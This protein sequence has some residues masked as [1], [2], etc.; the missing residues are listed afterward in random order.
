VY[1]DANASGSFS[2]TADPVVS[3]SAATAYAGGGFTGSNTYDINSTVG[4]WPNNLLPLV[5]NGQNLLSV[6]NIAF[7]ND[8]EAVYYS[9]DVNAST[10]PSGIT[11]SADG[12]KITIAGLLIWQ[13]SNGWYNSNSDVNRRLK[14]T[15]GAG[16]SVYTP[17][18]ETNPYAN[19]SGVIPVQITSLGGTGWNQHDGNNHFER[20]GT[21]VINGSGLAGVSHVTLT[22]KN[23]F[24]I[25]LVNP[26][27]VDG[28]DVNA[29]ATA[30]SIGA[31]MFNAD[32]NLL[33]SVVIGSRR[34]KLFFADASI[35]MS[36]VNGTA[37]AFTVSDLP[38][39]NKTAGAYAQTFAGVGD[40]NAQ[41]GIYDNS[42]GNGNISITSLGKN[43][44]GVIEIQFRDTS[45]GIFPMTALTERQWTMSS[46]GLTITIAE[47]YIP[48]AWH[49]VG[50]GN[51]DRFIRLITPAGSTVDTVEITAQD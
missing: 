4:L 49:A 25:P 47:I 7:V 31:N 3:G 10:P 6:G 22:D 50:D 21:L 13:K 9:F 5:I 18:I 17:Y 32:A 20:N 27:V 26:L 37:G 29:S 24:E 35:L 48:A 23:G 51:A 1:S 42:V 43:M 39:I 16:Q 38:D 19:D 8:P 12:K 41:S 15:S 36:E 46:D 44:R 34:V 33:D 28:V 45:A 2:L 30:V 40:G 11:F 14:L